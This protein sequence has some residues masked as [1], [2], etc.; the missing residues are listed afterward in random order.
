MNT[1]ALARSRVAWAALKERIVDKKTNDPTDSRKVHVY[2]RCPLER[3]DMAPIFDGFRALDYDMEGVFLDHASGGLPD[4]GAVWGKSKPCADIAQ[5]LREA[6]KQPII[7]EA[8]FFGRS[9]G[10]AGRVGDTA[11]ASAALSRVA[12]A[13][14][15]EP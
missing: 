6:G 10:D 4:V 14:P 1:A 11:G 2:Y 7:A 15:V 3:S 9:A 5:R 8:A 12:G 13:A